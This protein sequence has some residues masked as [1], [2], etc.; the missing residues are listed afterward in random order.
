MSHLH[1]LMPSEKH[2]PNIKHA[3]SSVLKSWMRCFCWI[4]FDCWPEFFKVYGGMWK[5]VQNHSTFFDLRFSWRVKNIIWGNGI[6][7]KCLGHPVSTGCPRTNTIPVT[8]M[9]GLSG[10]WQI[11]DITWAGNHSVGKVCIIKGL[12]IFGL[13]W[14]TSI[15]SIPAV[16]NASIC[17]DMSS[18]Q[19]GSQATHSFNQF[20]V[21]LPS[22]WKLLPLGTLQLLRNRTCWNNGR[23]VRKSKNC[24]W[25]SVRISVGD[26]WT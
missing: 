16:T 18:I 23:P 8:W 17:A 15:P 25:L 26:L 20:L 24:E 19:F 10:S 6:G 11:P 7:W 14:T 9:F 1:S 12:N 2:V 13:P 3:S 22:V 4:F 21:R 5:P